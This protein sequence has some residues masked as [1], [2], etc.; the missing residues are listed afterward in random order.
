MTSRIHSDE[1]IHLEVEVTLN[2]LQPS[3]V[4]VECLFGQNKTHDNWLTQQRFSTNSS[5]ESNTDDTGNPP[6]TQVY[7]LTIQV[8]L[9]GLQNFR[10]RLV[11]CHP[12]QLHPYEL[13][14][15][16]WL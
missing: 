16:K 10:L 6:R 5:P 15:M 4:V 3:E 2:G 13:G 14:L 11:P 12:A 8:S 1:E 9:S 7:H